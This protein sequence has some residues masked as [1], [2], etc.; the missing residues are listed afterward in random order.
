VTKKKEVKQEVVLKEKISP[1]SATVSVQNGNMGSGFGGSISSSQY[2][3]MASGFGG[4]MGPGQ[5]GLMGNGY[6]ELMGPIA[7]SQSGNG[8]YGGGF[9]ASNL[10]AGLGCFQADVNNKKNGN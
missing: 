6:A 5:Y 9:G 1:V 2:G 7:S 4:L 8:G 3:Q 10:M